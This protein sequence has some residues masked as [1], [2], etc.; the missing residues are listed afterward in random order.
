MFVGGLSDDCHRYSYTPSASTGSQVPLLV[1]LYSVTPTVPDEGEI[2]G[3]TVLIGA[4]RDTDT[5][6]L[7]EVKEVEY[8]EFTA[9][10]EKR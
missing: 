1:T 2:V 7:V 5:E 9:V 10:T 8:V 3:A 6:P 4:G